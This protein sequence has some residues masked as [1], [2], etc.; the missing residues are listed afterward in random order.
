M[1]YQCDK[2]RWF[3]NK[4]PETKH[5]TGSQPLNFLA[6]LEIIGVNPRFSF[7]TFSLPHVNK[8]RCGSG[9]LLHYSDYLR[10][11][12]CS[13]RGKWNA[14]E[15][16]MVLCGNPL[17]TGYKKEKNK[18]QRKTFTSADVWVCL[19]KRMADHGYRIGAS[20]YHGA[21]R[22]LLREPEAASG[23]CLI[24]A[25]LGAFVHGFLSGRA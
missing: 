7:A 17:C 23:T 6:I 8:M 19:K 11:S 5:S 25:F 20:L 16:K 15:M 14:N 13:T 18:K 12:F 3:K 21:E 1:K 2:I 10:K 4:F 24:I 22:R 9:K